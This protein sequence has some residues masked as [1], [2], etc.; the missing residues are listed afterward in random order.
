MKV[1]V[2]T[3][4]VLSEDKIRMM[5]YGADGF[6]VKPLSMESLISKVNLIA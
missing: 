4:K 6:A 3:D 2:L 1:F 5:E